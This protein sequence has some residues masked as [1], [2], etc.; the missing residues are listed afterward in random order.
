LSL[1]PFSEVL[2]LVIVCR[3]ASSWSIWAFSCTARFLLPPQS[4]RN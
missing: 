2:L 4:H 1:A 3:A